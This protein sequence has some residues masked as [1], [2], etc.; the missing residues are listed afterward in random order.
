MNK[1]G[2][3][4]ASSLRATNLTATKKVDV[5]VQLGVGNHTNLNKVKGRNITIKTGSGKE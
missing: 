1:E 4:K 3:G 2:E 5:V